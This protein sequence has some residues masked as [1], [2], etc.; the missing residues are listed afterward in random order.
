MRRIVF[1]LLLFS[2]AASA[3]STSSK[4]I[5]N[6]T[7]AWYSINS[8]LRF[9]QRW[10]A[11]GDI[12]VRTEGLSENGVFW[13]VRAGGVYW[14][15]G[16][17]PIIAGVARLWLNPPSG[18]KTWATE[19]RIYQQ[20]ST[21]MAYGRISTIH[22]IRTEERW[23]D[24]INN[25]QIFGS[26]VFSFRLR[27]LL[28]VQIPISGNPKVP[29]L[30]V[31]NELMAQFSTSIAYNTFDQN[32]IFVGIRVPISKDLS[33]DTGFMNILQQRASGNVYDLSNVFRLFVYWNVDYYTNKKL[34]LGDLSDD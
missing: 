10:G 34:R 33:F 11:V 4:Q 22:R 25:D 23:R 6:H 2:F 5:I 12:H 15:Q 13:L 21:P 19:N 17:Y 18:M 16:K 1:L 8:S 30:V 27:Y 9:S 14:I 31:A 32:R 7:Q 20:W 28:S 29:A 26:K 3:Q 24:L